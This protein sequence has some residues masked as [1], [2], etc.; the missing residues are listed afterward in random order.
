MPSP[1]SLFA[2]SAL[3]LAL[4]SS[5]CTS[6]PETGAKEIQVDN[7]AEVPVI[8]AVGATD[9]GSV[10]AETLTAPLAVANGALALRID[11]RQVDTLELG[12]DNV[13]GLWEL[14]VGY[15]GTAS[16]QQ[17]YWGITAVE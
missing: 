7:Q 16:N 6:D 14:T 9:F 8:V 11:G 12:S 1:R 3:A 13:S 2:V 17:L 4:A 10:T 15:A 5:A